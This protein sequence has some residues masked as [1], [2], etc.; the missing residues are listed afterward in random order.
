MPFNSAIKIVESLF[1]KADQWNLQLPKLIL[2]TGTLGRFT[3]LCLFNFPRRRDWIPDSYSCKYYL[4]VR[5]SVWCIEWFEV[6]PAF[7]LFRDDSKWQAVSLLY[8]CINKLSL[9]DL[10]SP[11]SSMMSHN[12]FSGLFHIFMLFIRWDIQSMDRFAS[13]RGWHL[14]CALCS[15]ISRHFPHCSS[16]LTRLANHV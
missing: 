5:K 8:D 6:I 3:F 2:S 7:K 16:F 9:L 12:H 10:A 15:S 11:N 13:R 1:V 14:P 4:F